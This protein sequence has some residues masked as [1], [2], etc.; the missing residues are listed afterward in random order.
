MIL[1]NCNKC[2]PEIAE[3]LVEVGDKAHFKR[4]LIPCASYLD[5]T[6]RMCGLLTRLYSE[7]ATALAQVV[8]G[9]SEKKH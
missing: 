2:L 5:A 4:L 6:Y 9:E 8:I 7:Q 3:A 1:T